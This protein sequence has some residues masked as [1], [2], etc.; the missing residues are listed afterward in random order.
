MAK[1][2][3]E[4]LK[5]IPVIDITGPDAANVPIHAIRFDSRQVQPGDLFV[6]VRGVGADGHQFVDAAIQNGAVAIVCETTPLLNGPDTTVV[7]V[8]DCM[9][10]LGQLAANFYENPSKQLQLVGITGTNGKTTTVT[11]LWQLFTRLGYRCGL[12]GTVENRIGTEILPS[13]HTTPDA[14][15]LHGLLRQMK[16]A[17]CTYVFM[18]VSSHA[19]HQ[20]RIAGA[21]FRGAAFSNITHDHLDYHNTFAE[22][23]DVKKQLFDRLPSTAF[24]LTNVDDKNGLFMMQNTRASVHTYGLK[25]PAAFKAKIIENSLMGLYMQLDGQPFHARMIG[26]FNAYNLTATYACARLL[27]IEKMDILTALSDLNGA[28]GRFDH[29]LHPTKKCIGIVDYAHTPDAVEKVLET[30]RKLKNQSAKVITVIG[31]G[32]DR[33]KT[34]RPLMARVAAQLSDQ[35]ILTSDNPRTEAPEAILKDME[36]GLHAGDL[37][38]TLTIENREQA[39]KTACRL[40]EMNDIILVAGKGHEKYQDIQGVKHPFDDKAVLLKYFQT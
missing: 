38:K 14:V 1:T 3:F 32:G 6:A 10:V 4:I 26:E 7:I 16:D 19:I 17:G 12:I 15:R 20:R 35:V 34:K 36:A 11:L 28:E 13:T 8:D 23:R 27:G 40:A 37:Q 33:D 29:I 22:Y 39:I 5:D 21:A 9:A 2:L 24:A 31:C 30:I 25:K 18:E